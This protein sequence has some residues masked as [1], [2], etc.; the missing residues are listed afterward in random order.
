MHGTQAVAGSLSKSAVPAG[1]GGGVGAG[2]ATVQ[3]SVAVHG[4][5][6]HVMLAGLLSRALV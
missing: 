5:P 2:G 3:H 4:S 1:Q 6:E